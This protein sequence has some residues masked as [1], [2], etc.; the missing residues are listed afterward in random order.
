[1]KLFSYGNIF[2]QIIQ[3]KIGRFFTRIYIIYVNEI[4]G[5]FFKDNKWNKQKGEEMFLET[6]SVFTKIQNS[7]PKNMKC[8]IFLKHTSPP[9]LLGIFHSFSF[10]KLAY[11]VYIQPSIIEFFVVSSELKVVFAA[12]YLFVYSLHLTLQVFLI[13]LCI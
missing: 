4:L 12:S 5:K 6:K 11:V 3:I 13:F 7:L 9:Y 8:R 1:M 2:F 10:S